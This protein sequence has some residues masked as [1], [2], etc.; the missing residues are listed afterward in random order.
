MKRLLIMLLIW[1]YA[2][3]FSQS[4]AFRSLRYEEDYTYLKNDSSV[5]WYDKMKYSPLPGNGKDYI[6]YGGEI[7]Y[8]YFYI[9]NEAWGDAPVDGD[10]YMLNRFLVHADLHAGKNFRVFAQLQSSLSGSRINASPVDDNP[11]ELHQTF[12]DINANPAT[13]PQLTVR[14]GRQEFLYGSQRLISVREGPNNRQS[15]DA[16]RFLLALR[17]Y[18]LDIFFGYQ[19]V[20]RKRIFNDKF[21]A[22]VKLWGAYI[23]RNKIPALKNADFYYLSL[24]KQ[25]T[26]FD[27]GQG[28][29]LR[30]SIG[31]RVWD[32]GDDWKYDFEALYQFGKFADKSIRAWTV[33]ISTSYSSSQAKL[34]PQIGLKAELISGDKYFNDDRLQTFNPLFPRGAYFGLA[35]VIGPANLVDIHPSVL[36]SIT[37]KT[38]ISIDYDIFWRYSRNDGLYAVNGSLLYSGRNTDD[39]YIGGQLG[40]SFM[41]ASNSYLDFTAECAWFDTGNFLKRVSPGKNILFTGISAQLKF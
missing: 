4:P 25:R 35:A 5:N 31:G 3:G 9:K 19:A 17:N 40:L 38:D 30:Q 27:D 32:N 10:G 20:A 37:K 13:A 33:S 24:R 28:K 12:L 21:S 14:I 15:F 36:F 29:E 8:Q 2:N 11:L 18:K 23:I 34:Q 16:I 22:D 41:Y 26:A 7:R 1:S 39:K 6:S